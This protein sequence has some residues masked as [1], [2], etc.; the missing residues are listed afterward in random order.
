MSSSHFKECIFQYTYNLNLTSLL[1]IME[2][3]NTWDKTKKI[4]FYPRFHILHVHPTSLPHIRTFYGVSAPFY[5]TSNELRWLLHSTT[6][7]HLP[8]IP[9]FLN[10][11]VHCLGGSTTCPVL[12]GVPAF[13]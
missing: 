4:H 6:C 13:L 3:Y 7:P 2:T 8:E 10:Q 11:G 5:H 9:A 12:P 1:V